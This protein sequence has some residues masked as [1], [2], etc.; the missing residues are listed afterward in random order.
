MPQ[1]RARLLACLVILPVLPLLALYANDPKPP[2][3][4][5]RGEVTKYSFDQSKIFPGTVRDYWVYVPKQY[6]PAKPACV[7][8]NQDGIQFNAPAVFDELIHKKEMPVTVGVFVMHGKVKAP[9]DKALDRF[10]RSYEYDGLGDNYARFLLD[11]LL[12]E[13]EKKTTSDGRPIRLSKEGNDRSIAGTSSGAICAFTAAWERPDAF[14]RVF[15]GV[16]TYV[17]L[18]GGNNYPTLIRKYEPKPIRIF[19]EDGS[20]DLNIYGGDWWMANQEMERALTF[21]GYE[22]KHAWGEG[23]HNNKHATEVFPEAMRWLWKDWPAPVKAGLGSPE[24]KSILLPGEDWQ[25]V[26]DGFRFT[27]GPAANAK[28]EVFFNDIPNSKTHKIGLDGK[29]S[30]FVADSKKGNGQAFG[31]DGRLYAVASGTHQVV[32][33]DAEGKAEVIAEGI[34]GNDLVVRHDGGIYVTHP[35]GGGNP[36][37]VWYINPKGEKR[38]VDTGL[39]FSNG[40]T[41]SPDQTLLYVA[42]THTH[43]VYSFQVQPDGS[44]TAKQRYYHLHVPDTADDS[45]A[46]GMRVDRDGRL[47]VATRLGIQVCDQAGRVNCIIPTPNGKIANLC[48]GGENGDTLFA[49]C[50]DRVFKRKL[51]VK[52]AHAFQA[53]FKPAGPNL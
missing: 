15:S 21:A 24:L 14:R 53:P 31:P 40:I 7:H 47:Y 20:G 27:E 12:P 49:T 2:S 48:F 50:G 30:V 41:L 37:L 45:G 25:L 32:A 39:K 29:V 1:P 3:D 16:G 38:V 22:V 35:G 13:V 34:A 46:D 36:S 33:Y 18:R 52:G 26:A 11:E 4:V 51:K 44:L 43:W 9:S 28:G 17:G 6:D 23:G 8:V 42:D 19:L 5:P 10:N